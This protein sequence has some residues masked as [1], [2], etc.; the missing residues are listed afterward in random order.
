MDKNSMT[1]DKLIE[2][3]QMAKERGLSGSDL[4]Y[5]YDDKGCLT[6][7]FSVFIESRDIVLEK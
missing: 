7:E 6:D 1:I 2:A 5:T 4:V 3:L